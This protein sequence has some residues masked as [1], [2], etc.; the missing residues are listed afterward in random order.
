MDNHKKMKKLWMVPLLLV[1]ILIGRT[2][3]LAKELF[4]TEEEIAYLEKKK[5]VRACSIDGGAPLH[6]LNSKGE[7]VGIAVSILDNIGE[8]TGIQFEYKLYDSIYD[9]FESNYDIIFGITSQYA[10]KDMILSRPYLKSQT[11]LFFNSS[12]DSNELEGKIY[13]SIKGGS[14]PDGV[15]EENTIYYNSREA[16]LNAVENGHADYGYGNEYS[17]A[18]YSLQNNYKNII[19]IPIRK[20]NREYSIG[21]I[22]EDPK[23]LSIINK[24]IDSIDDNQLSNIVLNISS[25]VERKVT[26]SMIMDA[27][28]KRIVGIFIIVISLLLRSL[29]LNIRAKKN[30]RLQNTIH[31]ILSH[32]SD[33][34]LFEYNIKADDLKMSK[35]S[36]SLFGSK[37]NLD[38]V[39][40]T[41]KNM[42]L[43][44]ESDEI[45]PR[46]KLPFNNG[47]S[48]VFKIIKSTMYDKKRKRYY[49]VGKLINIS[50]EIAEKEKLKIKAQTDGLTGL[51]NAATTKKLIEQ[52]VKNK[53]ND[54]TDTLLIID[55]DE[56]KDIND[57]FGHLAGDRA[58]KIVSEALKNTFRETDVV[59][60]IGGDEFSVYMENI[61]SI[62]FIRSKC[63][64]LIA[65]V[66]ETDKKLNLKLSIGIALLKD[67]KE[68]ADLFKQADDALYKAKRSGGGKAVLG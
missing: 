44:K 43:E 36:M 65:L 49:I 28:G 26:F 17:L 18:F 66:Q 48:G 15:K 9:V 23:L 39:T 27:Y 6:Y 68:P 11:I 35:K 52:S 55:C 54:S 50:K 33:E 40:K 3:S 38:K 5:T 61:P 25:Q 2:A 58:L 32:I 30:L 53:K 37:E 22:K 24:S 31:E 7:I 57:T 20:E 59:G 29:I 47:D 13:A 34:Y 14:L 10:P 19:A 62:N 45:I 67:K 46:I 42:V 1:F 16:T 56:F 21:F 4:L 51:Y 8:I 41:L 64:S 60:R 63:E 12:M